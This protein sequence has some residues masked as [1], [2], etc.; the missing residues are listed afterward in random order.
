M[1]VALA[2]VSSGTDPEANLG[3]IG[4]WTARAAAADADLV[5]FGEAMMCRFGVAL[6]PVAQPLDGAWATAVSTVA[7]QHGVTV[8]A[9][10]FTPAPDG[11]ERVF[12]TLLIAHPDQRREGYHKIHLYDAYG[13]RESDTVAA[14][15]TPLVTEIAG[16]RVGVATCYDI[17]FPGL[18]TALADQG[19]EM[20]VVPASWGD[21]PGKVD[22]WQVL[23]R[24]RA[25]DSSTVVAAVGQ[26]VPTDQAAIDAPAPTG[27]G[28]SMLVDPFG[29]VVTE[30]GPQEQLVVNDIPFAQVRRARESIAVLDNRVS[31]R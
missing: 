7:G 20:I 23:A 8:I 30:C 4:D 5:V 11:S 13:F 21:G 9:G 29:V 28:H 1:R 26:P 17:R 27:V 3:L 31:W 15:S 14:G 6:H 12:N 22:Q 19:A 24:A 18:F 25:L 10:M 16:H 2:Q